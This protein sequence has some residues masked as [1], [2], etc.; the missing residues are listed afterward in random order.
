M[1]M[2]Y[3]WCC[4]RSGGHHLDCFDRVLVVRYNIFCDTLK[5]NGISTVVS[6]RHP[7]KLSL[8]VIPAKV[9]R[10]GSDGLM[11][12]AF[13]LTMDRAVQNFALAGDIVLCS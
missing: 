11:V 1:E 2:D 8:R 12:S 7:I 9:Y 13:R 4:C 6:H 3:N 5:P 10:G